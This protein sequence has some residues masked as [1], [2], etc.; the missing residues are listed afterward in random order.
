[1]VTQDELANAANVVTEAFQGVANVKAFCNEM[2]EQKRYDAR[3]NIFLKTVR[4]GAIARAALVA[5]IIF[6]IFTAITIVLWY[7]TE[8]LLDGTLKAGDLLGFT[9]YTM[10]IGG[11]LGSFADL[12]SN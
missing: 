5:F 6:A 2:F 7:G 10:F 3:I 12:Y 8:Q 9:F 4:Q 11:S 1:R